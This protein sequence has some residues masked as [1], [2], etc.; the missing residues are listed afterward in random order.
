MTQRTN[1]ALVDSDFRRRAA[2]TLRLD[3]D[4]HLKLRLAC[5]PVLVQNHPDNAAVEKLREFGALL[6][7]LAA[8]V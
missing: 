6:G 1:L 7:K 8:A 2:F 5:A 3:K 4:R